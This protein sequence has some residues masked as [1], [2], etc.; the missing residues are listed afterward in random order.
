MSGGQYTW[1]NNHIDR[2]LEKLDSFL[3]SS[4]W[5]DSFPLTIVHKLARD[6]SD[7][8]PLILDNIEA[9]EN[10]NRDFRFENRWVKENDFLDMV[11][12]IW[13]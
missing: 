10:K 11:N 6:I 1:S 2:T 13:F 8:N 9:K 3:M 12:I 7:H 5:E 4:S